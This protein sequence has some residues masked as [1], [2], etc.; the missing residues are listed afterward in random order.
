MLAPGRE[1][2][3]SLDR[4]STAQLP[5]GAGDYG[6][7]A[8]HD[9]HHGKYEAPVQVPHIETVAAFSHY[10][11]LPCTVVPQTIS[12]YVSPFLSVDPLLHPP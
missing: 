4:M 8:A 1:P 6:I 2:F 10:V 5:N 3:D 7:S 9:E 12:K 11:L